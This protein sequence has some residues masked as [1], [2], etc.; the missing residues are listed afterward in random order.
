M[1]RCN[2]LTNHFG[3]WLFAISVKFRA[4][5][6]NRFLFVICSISALA[7]FGLPATEPLAETPKK[8]VS[9]RYQGVTVE[10]PYQWLEKD[11]EPD[12]KAWSDAQ[13]QRTRQYLDQLPDR[14]AIEKQLTE[15][16]KKT[17]PSYSRLFHDPVLFVR[18]SSRKNNRCEYSMLD[19]LKSRKSCLIERAG[20]N[21]TAIDWFVPKMGPSICRGVAFKVEGEDILHFRDTPLAKRRTLPAFSIRR[22]AAV[23]GTPTAQ[24]PR[25]PESGGPKLT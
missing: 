21:P 1:L 25:F 5:K 3:D 18:N 15:K 12:V 19:D 4:M 2:D 9:T 23:H 16:K 7:L 13:N 6:T 10:D 14:A 11:G 17:S 8:P 22:Q 20:R 24:T